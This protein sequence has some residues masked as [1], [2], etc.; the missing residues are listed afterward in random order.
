MPPIFSPC[1]DQGQASVNS[2]SPS[3]LH[4]LGVVL[5]IGGVDSDAFIFGSLRQ[6]GTTAARN[7]S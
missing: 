1:A 4:N 5:D 7:A 3:E 2:G 6:G